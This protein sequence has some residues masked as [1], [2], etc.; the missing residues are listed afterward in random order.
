MKKEFNKNMVSVRKDNQTE[1]LEIKFLKSNK[2]H[3]WKKLKQ[4][5]TSE[6]TEF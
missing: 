5:R 3:S 2:K 6:K 1:I 4:T